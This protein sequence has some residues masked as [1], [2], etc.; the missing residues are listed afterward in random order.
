VDSDKKLE[1]SD[2]LK[3]TQA[4]SAWKAEELQTLSGVW[5]TQKQNLEESWCKLRALAEVWLKRVPASP[6][7]GSSGWRKYCKKGKL[8][9]FSISKVLHQ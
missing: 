3:G 6:A 7:I 1:A 2:F 5:R 9:N 4:N 8:M